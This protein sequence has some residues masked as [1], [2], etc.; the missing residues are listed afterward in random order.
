M[1][2]RKG[3][4]EIEDQPGENLKEKHAESIQNIAQTDD[5]SWRKIRRKFW[6]KLTLTVLIGSLS[7]LILFLLFLPMIYAISSYTGPTPLAQ[8]IVVICALCLLPFMVS[9]VFL[10]L[11]IQY[12]KKYIKGRVSGKKIIRVTG[13]VLTPL[14]LFIL[15]LALSGFN[16]L[17]IFEDAKQIIDRAGRETTET[18]CSEGGDEYTDCTKAENDE[19]TQPEKPERV[20]TE[21]ATNC[22]STNNGYST[23]ITEM[24]HLMFDVP[25]DW[26]V[27]HIKKQ[28]TPPSGPGVS[29]LS[30]ITSI[31]S[32]SGYS[33][34]LTEYDMPAQVGG[35]CDWEEEE[36][37]PSKVIHKEASGLMAGYQVISNSSRSDLRLSAFAGPYDTPVNSCATM[38]DWIIGDGSGFALPSG[39]I[40]FANRNFDGYPDNLTPPPTNE[41]AEVVKILASLRQ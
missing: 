33:V 22:R 21:I 29:N 28:L 8:V 24:Y 20:T 34:Y 6:V 36:V 3:F 10:V 41:Y 11:T 2:A 26:T 4:M 1:T 25:A 5:E 30:Y 7:L 32:I 37:H 12:Y 31:T 39:S 14:I 35:S 17:A 9:V 38:Y 40:I 15:I 18:E 19:A 13:M 16:L 27:K 23:C